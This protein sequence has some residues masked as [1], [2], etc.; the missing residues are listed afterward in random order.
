VLAVMLLS[1]RE[2]TE[3]IGLRISVGARRK[4]IVRQFLTE[5][6]ML[7]LA[8]GIAGVASGL[9]MAWVIGQTT[10]WQT[11]ISTDS[12]VLP[13]A[14]SIITGLIFGV[15]PARKAAKLDPI[16]ALQKE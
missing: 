6:S 14:F 4:D 2:R 7:G 5:A 11:S 10:Q 3:E 9:L 15:F 1:I 16:E 13:L 8:G 12:I